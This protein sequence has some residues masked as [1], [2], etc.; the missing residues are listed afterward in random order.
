MNL[1]ILKETFA[2]FVRVH[3]M[4][5]HFRRLVILDVLRSAPEIGRAHV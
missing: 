3:G 4:A 5:H 2:N 1:N